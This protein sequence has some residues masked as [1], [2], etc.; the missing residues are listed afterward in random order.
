MLLLLQAA[1]VLLQRFATLG[2]SRGDVVRML[3]LS[4]WE[5]RLCTSLYVFVPFLSLFIFYSIQ[6]LTC[7]HTYLH[8]YIYI[9]VVI[10]FSVFTR[11]WMQQS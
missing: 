7:M 6:I 4:D 11:R 5:V 1:Q 10:V 8:I 3:L 2:V 9:V